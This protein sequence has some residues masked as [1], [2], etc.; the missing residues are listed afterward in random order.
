MTLHGGLGPLALL[1]GAAQRLVAEYVLAGVQGILDHP[2]VLGGGGND[3]DG[4]NVGLIDHLL[5][6]GGNELDLKRILRP[7]QFFFHQRTGGDQLAA[8][9]FE[10]QIFSMDRAET[11]QTNDTNFYFFHTNSPLVFLTPFAVWSSFVNRLPLL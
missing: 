6:V 3:D 10:C 9:D 7:F 11:A 4:L 8:G 2:A 1:Q 5:V